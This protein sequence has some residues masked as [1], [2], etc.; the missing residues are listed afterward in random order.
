MSTDMSTALPEPGNILRKQFSNGLTVLVHE[1]PWSSTAAL[2]GSLFAGSGLDPEDKFGLSTFVSSSLL[3]GT[4]S[5][6]SARISEYLESISAVLSFNSSPHKIGFKGSC[7]SEDLP[8]YLKLLKEILDEPVFPAHHLEVFRQQALEGYAQN[9]DDTD[10]IEYRKFKELLWG[11]GHPYS[12]PE[13]EP[14]VIR[15][16]TRDDLVDF[17]SRYFGPKKCI[18]AIAGGFRGQEIMDRCEEIF[19]SWEKDQEDADE[20][21]L[22][23]PVERYEHSIR[24]HIN[25]ASC[26]E[27]SLV[28]RGNSIIWNNF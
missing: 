19:G 18:L 4:R 26:K 7:L 22:F 1:N 3:A 24:M 10:D 28:I 16:F 15:N 11:E 23:P 2:Y 14:E 9:T 8:D 13:F 25:I 20:D 27:I 21:E 17:H 5:R 12:C 6:S